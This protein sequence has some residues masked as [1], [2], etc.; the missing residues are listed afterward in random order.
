MNFK[1]QLEYLGVDKSFIID[2]EDRPYNS[3]I[4]NLGKI[5]IIDTFQEMLSPSEQLRCL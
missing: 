3:A 5:R 2:S 4:K 1:D